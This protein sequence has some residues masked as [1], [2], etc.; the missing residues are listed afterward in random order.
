[1]KTLVYKVVLS[2]KRYREEF[3]F[4]QSRTLSIFPRHN[5][6]SAKWNGYN[7]IDIISWEKK[8]HVVKHTHTRKWMAADEGI[9]IVEF[10]LTY[11]DSLSENF[12]VYWNSCNTWSHC[13]FV[14]FFLLQFLQAKKRLNA[15]IFAKKGSISTWWLLLE[16]AKRWQNNT[17]RS[18]EIESSRNRSK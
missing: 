14:W 3:I 1:M 12:D 16:K 13:F 11:S 4:V 7:Q 18:Y 15:T 8:K 9:W 6:I 10:I 2:L 5:G 17:W